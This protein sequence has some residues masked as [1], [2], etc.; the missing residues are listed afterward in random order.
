MH[1]KQTLSS[2]GV[3]YKLS[4]AATAGAVPAAAAVGYTHFRTKRGRWRPIAE[5]KS[6]GWGGHRHGQRG[7]A[8]TRQNRRPV[9]AA[10][11][12]AV[13]QPGSSQEAGGSAPPPRASG[14]SPHQGAGG[15]AP[16]RTRKRRFAFPS[17][18][19]PRTLSICP[20]TRVGER[21]RGE[22]STRC[23]RCSASC[24]GASVAPTWS[25]ARNVRRWGPA[26]YT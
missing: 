9:L 17:R 10:R 4:V 13:S 16:P 11:S 15:S 5:F 22:R 12:K 20:R 7:H 25:A 19:H 24:P 18:R 23:S 21:R 6:Q 14:C 2:R 26:G 3:R 8:P 1:G